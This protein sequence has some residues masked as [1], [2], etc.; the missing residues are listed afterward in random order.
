MFLSYCWF[1]TPPI[2]RAR[3]L[4][5]LE[6][7]SELN[8]NCHVLQG[9][10]A[11]AVLRLHRFAY[12]GSGGTADFPRGAAWVHFTE[13]VRLRP[14]PISISLSLTALHTVLHKTPP[15]RS[16]PKTLQSNAAS[17]LPHAI[18]YKYKEVGRLCAPE[19][20]RVQKKFARSSQECLQTYRSGFSQGVARTLLFHLSSLIPHNWKRHAHKCCSLRSLRDFALIGKLQN[21]INYCSMC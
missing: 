5:S 7:I 16:L 18:E 20:K 17:Q 4:L 19:F 14:P 11:A 3:S 2:S 6:M 21:C 9:R 15:I 13:Q 8:V 10:A 12:R 1:S